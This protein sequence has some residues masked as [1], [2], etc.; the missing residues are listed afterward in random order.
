[1]NVGSPAK[2]RRLLSESFKRFDDGFRPI[3]E[4]SDKETGRQH[5]GPAQCGYVTVRSSFPMINRRFRLLGK[6]FAECKQVFIDTIE[7]IPLTR[8]KLRLPSVDVNDDSPHV[9]ENHPIMRD[10]EH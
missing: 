4:A 3:V 9:A 6:D 7:V 2:S 5:D 1:M 10:G 8:I